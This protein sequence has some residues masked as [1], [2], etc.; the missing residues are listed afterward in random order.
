MVFQETALKGAFVIEVEVHADERGGFGRTYCWREFQEHGLVPRVVQ[1]SVSYNTKRGTLRGMHCQET[2]HEEAKLIR[3]ARGA[4]FD[5][6]VDLRSSSPTFRQ[7]AAFELKAEPGKP[8]RMVY[9]PPGFAHGF[10]TL[11]DDTEIVYQMSEFYAPRAARGFRWND[12][13][14]DIHWPAPVAVISD[15]DRGYPDFVVNEAAVES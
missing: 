12:P 14:F 7:W 9:V 11:Q 6:I 2:P 13:A 8:S 10:L 3:C 15:R 5:V 4:M 1:C